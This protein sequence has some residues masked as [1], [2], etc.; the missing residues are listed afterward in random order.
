LLRTSNAT[1]ERRERYH[2]EGVKYFLN[3]GVSLVVWLYT[4]FVLTMLWDWFVT[5]AFHVGEIAYWNMYGLVLAIRLLSPSAEAALLLAQKWE[6]AM[7]MLEACIPE[8]RRTEVMRDLDKD[9]VGTN[10]QLLIANAT[11]LAGSTMSLVI[12]FAIH[13][14][15]MA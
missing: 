11:G 12:G 2:G 10:A 4:T 14:F 15:L 9:K 3:L 6:F 13:T 7:K 8:D 1:D 5:A